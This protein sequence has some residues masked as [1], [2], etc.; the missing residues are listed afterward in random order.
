MVS[1][2]KQYLVRRWTYVLQALIMLELLI[3][4]EASDHMLWV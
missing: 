4:L 3:Q 1:V 2:V